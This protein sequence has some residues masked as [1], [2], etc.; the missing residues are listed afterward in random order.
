[1]DTTDEVRDALIAIAREK[2]DWRGPLP[3]ADIE[4]ARALDS[5]QMLALVVAVE[6]RFRICLDP[7]DEARIRTLP[8][9]VDVIRSKRGA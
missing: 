5:L 4:L 3:G 8:D 6:D 7:E 2:L 1:M 9:L